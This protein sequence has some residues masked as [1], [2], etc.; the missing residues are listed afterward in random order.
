MT[1]AITIRREEG[2]LDVKQA[3]NLLME[4]SRDVFKKDVD[5][6]VI[7]GVDKPSLFQAGA[8]K[9]ARAFQLRPSYTALTALEDFNTP[10]FFYRIQC[11]LI[12]FPTGLVVGSGWGSANSRESKW[13]YRWLD[14]AQLSSHVDKTQLPSRSAEIVEFKFSVDKAETGG[15]Y[16]K[17][18]EYWNRFRDAIASGDARAIKKKAASG[19]EFDAWAI[20]GTQY[21]VVNPDIFDQLNTIT[22]MAAKRAFV[23]TVLATTGASE[24]YTQ[25]V[26][27]MAMFSITDAL[28]DPGMDV[29]IAS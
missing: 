11:D 6:G 5:Y 18:A 15:K 29:E 12:H 19:K 2:V 7:P 28:V 27:D 13:G 14:E 22:K 1:N 25:D 21:R 26:E 9:I 20:G 8:Q 24:L 3:L 16:G 23:G 10:L 4:L 17:P